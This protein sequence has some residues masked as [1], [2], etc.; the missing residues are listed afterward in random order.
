MQDLDVGIDSHTALARAQEIDPGLPQI[1]L[2]LAGDAASEF[3]YEDGLSELDQAERGLPGNAEIFHLRYWLLL[4]MGRNDEAFANIERALALDPKNVF[5]AENYGYDLIRKRRYDDA[6]AY[7]S[8]A[9][10]NFDGAWGLKRVRAELDFFQYGE[11]LPLVDVW[12][13][14]DAPREAP[15]YEFYLAGIFWDT[16]D[17]NAAVAHAREATVGFEGPTSYLTAE[18]RRAWIF[19]DAGLDAESRAAAELAW[20]K[21]LQSREE[22]PDDPFPIL[23]LAR[24]RALDGDN[25]SALELAR[26]S[27]QVAQSNMTNRDQYNY[28]RFRID[29]AETL[30]V[31]GELDSVENMWR[32]FLS[33]ENEYTLASLLQQ[34]LPC[35]RQII[36]TEHYRRLEEEFGHLSEGV[37]VTQR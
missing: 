27:A 35:K 12:S 28:Q 32:E 36:D 29:Y 24:L 30:C 23:A 31:A 22:R 26:E 3:R 7:F 4:R 13:G 9:L 6:R 11:I 18:E 5:V 2:V 20:Q 10:V 33:E 1:R 25:A 34:L 17:M 15:F 14:P 21:A 19:R 37:S 8:A 16:G